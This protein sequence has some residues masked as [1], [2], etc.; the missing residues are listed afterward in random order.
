V[1]ATPQRP[2]P[3]QVAAAPGRIRPLLRTQ[4]QQNDDVRAAYDTWKAAYVLAAGAENDGTP[5]YRILTRVFPG[6]RDTVSEGQGYGMI[7]VALL[8]G[9][10]PQAQEIFDG[11]WEYARDHRSMADARLMDW[12]VPEDESDEGDN[13]TS[14]FDGDADIA[15]ALLLADNQ[16]GSTGRI[17]YLSEARTVLAGLL[18]TTIGIESRL[19]LLGDWV[20]QN[21]AQF[22]QYTN[23]TSD[24]MPQHFDVFAAAT[25]D[26]AWRDAARACRAAALALQMEYAPET[27]L[28]PDFVVATEADRS[29]RPA[30]P[31]FLEKPVDGA[32]NY[33]AGRTPWRF[34]VD[35]LLASNADS[36]LIAARMARWVAESTGGDPLAIRPGYALDGVP[37]VTPENYYFTAFFAAPLGV[38]AMNAPDLQDWLDAVYEAVR[39]PQPGEERGYYEDSVALLCLLIMTGNYWSPGS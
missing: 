19:P 11:F 35:G 32:F 14:A 5:R 28:L 31:N 4:Q 30:P 33:N 25:A 36:A 37:L 21:G 18:E 39:Q 16:W 23:R 1:A 6:D 34:G 20:D 24:F 12:H 9:H 2:F 38:A 27:G 26:T 3:Q 15:Y 17:D 13:D 7:A 29:P 10:D 22:N 8:A